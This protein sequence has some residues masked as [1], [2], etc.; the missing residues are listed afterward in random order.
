MADDTGRIVR[1]LLVKTA[2]FV[3][4]PLLLAV[5]AVVFLMPPPS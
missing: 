5:L 2:L 4:L 3:G 1:F